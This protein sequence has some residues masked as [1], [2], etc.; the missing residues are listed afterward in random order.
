MR[1]EPSYTEEPD[2]RDAAYLFALTSL[3][4]DG[5]E[6]STDDPDERDSE[7]FDSL[8]S[9]EPKLAAAEPTMQP[10]RSA[11]T[12]YRD[13]LAIALEATAGITPALD[14][15]DERSPVEVVDSDRF[16]S[17][18]DGLR[19]AMLR[20]EVLALGPICAGPGGSLWRYADGV[21]LSDGANEVRRRVA[22]LLGNRHRR[23][24][25]EGLVADLAA[26]HPLITDEQPTQFINCAN[27]LLDWRTLELHPHTPEVASTYQLTT[28]WNPDAACPMVDAWLA[29]VCPTDSLELAWEVVGTAIYADQPFHRAVLLLGPG[30]NGK[31]T[32]LRIVQALIGRA[33]VAAVPLQSLAENRFA[34]A[35]LFGKV[36]NISGDLDARAIKRTDLFKMATGGDLIL[37][38][39]KNGQPFQFTNRATFLF[40]AN[41][42][43]GSTDHTDGF[44]VR[45]VVIPFTRLQL[46]AGTE[47]ITLEPRLHTEMSGV[48]RRAVDGLRRA[49]RQGHYSTPASVTAATE[50]FRE[51]SDP[52]RRFLEDCV[53]I[54]G[55]HDD[56][57]SRR[58]LYGQ[59]GAWCDL[60]GHKTFGANRFWNRLPV[61]DSRIDIARIKAGTRFVGGVKLKRDWQ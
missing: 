42:P 2:E 4:R 16:F 7:Y 48:L 57:V 29:S 1:P 31:G 38:E 33:H 51:A 22:D 58:E 59:Y 5:A 9:D 15:E 10:D 25:A 46:A 35:E 17:R 19:H 6:L 50:G 49:M 34:T 54:T 40:S 60:N 30:R 14:A 61:I 39:R 37:A 26:K 27:G 52:L 18:I 55:H 53:T 43:P 11:G 36:A 47:D 8:T 20:C 56:I 41:E 3:E 23:S 44:F 32:F 12:A 45:W 24:H 21:W 13:A 28:A